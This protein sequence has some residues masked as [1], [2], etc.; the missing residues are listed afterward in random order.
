[1]KALTSPAYAKRK[2]V[3][4]VAGEAEAQTL[5]NTIIPFAFFLRVDRGAS[6]ATSSSSSS[7]P[8]LLQINQQQMFKPDEYYAWFY[9]GSQLT[10][11]L[12]GLGMVLVMLAAVMFPLWPTPLRTGVWYLSIGV[13]GLIGLFIAIAIVRLIFYIIT[14]VVA[15]PGIWVFPKLFADVGVVCDLLLLYL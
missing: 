6:A 8:K 1:M 3:P 7:S 2:N 11:Y 14:L 13:L 10:T 15:P 5:L 4:K 9:E 12:G